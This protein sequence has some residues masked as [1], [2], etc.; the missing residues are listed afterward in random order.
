MAEKGFWEKQLY[1]NPGVGR[2]IDYVGDIPSKIAGAI[3]EPRPPAFLPQTTAPVPAVVPAP[4]QT[5]APAAPARDPAWMYPESSSMQYT[6]KELTPE[7]RKY[8]VENATRIPEDGGRRTLPTR[9]EGGVRMMTVDGR[10]MDQAMRETRASERTA[11]VPA[12]TPQTRET[13]TAKRP[14]V[15]PRQAAQPPQETPSYGQQ[16]ASAVMQQYLDTG[17]APDVRQDPELLRNIP[18]PAGT[19]RI[20]RWAP[21]SVPQGNFMPQLVKYRPVVQQRPD[22]WTDPDTGAIYNGQTMRYAPPEE[23]APQA[24]MTREQQLRDMALNGTPEEKIWA[25]TQAKQDAA[26]DIEQTRDARAERVAQINAT[27]PGRR[28]AGQN[29]VSE[30]GGE[31]GPP[32]IKPTA[33]QRGKDFDNLMNMRTEVE[34]A[35]GTKEKAATPEGKAALK[36]YKFKYQD[37]LR[38]YGYDPFK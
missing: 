3:P 6:G 21:T 23:P 33:A 22:Q 16:A 17:I 4:V 5:A 11:A 1:G 13:A 15:V 24:P 20:E 36:R 32:K 38:T 30:V 29:Q 19:S 8:W 10:L 2:A 35:A 37:F 27:R 14:Q 7:Q 34:E 31:E 12:P 9:E 25:Y 18:V 28:G 26:M